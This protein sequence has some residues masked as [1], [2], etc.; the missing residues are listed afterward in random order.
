VDPEVRGPEPQTVLDDNWNAPVEPRL[1]K[2]T[3]VVPKPVEPA[4]TA[5]K[6]V[7]PAGTKP[8][9]GNTGNLAGEANTLFTQSAYEAALARER[10]RMGRT[11]IGVDPTAIADMVIVGGYHLERLAREGVKSFEQWAKAMRAEYG[12]LDKPQLKAVWKELAQQ[13]AIRGLVTHKFVERVDAS[14]EID[15]AT[16]ARLTEREYQPIKDATRREQVQAAAEG[17]TV[18]QVSA[19]ARDKNQ[20][21]PD[22]KRM[23][24]AA[25]A[26]TRLKQ[27]IQAARE[28]GDTT[29][30]ARLAKEQAAVL[31]TATT[32]YEQAGRTLRTARYAFSDVLGEMTRETLGD[33]ATKRLQSKMKQLTP[34]Q[35][36]VIDQMAADA[37]AAPAGFQ[38][39]EKLADLVRHV[40]R[41]TGVPF[42][43]LLLD[44]YYTHIFSGIG[45]HLRNVVDTNLNVLNETAILAANQLITGNPAAAGEILLALARGYGRGLRDAGG[46]MRT[47]VAS[48]THISQLETQSALDSIRFKGGRLNP[49]NAYKYV[50]RGLAAEDVTAFR[51]AEEAKAFDVAYRQARQSGLSRQAA[52]LEARK[53]LGLTADQRAAQLARAQTEGIKGNRLSRRVAEIR[54]QGRSESITDPAVEFGRRATYNADMQGSLAALGDA[55]GSMMN[56]A[57]VLRLIQPVVRIPINVFN[58]GLDY[59]PWGTVRATLGRRGNFLTGEWRDR[60]NGKMTAGERLT[61][62]EKSVGGTLAMAGIA[63]MAAQFMDDENPLFWVHGRGPLDPRQRVQWMNAGGKPYS[64]KINDQYVSYAYTPL[65][66]PMAALGGVL[67]QLRYNNK[68]LSMQD[69]GTQLAA[70]F[71]AMSSA[72]MEQ[73]F[74]SG[75]KDFIDGISDPRSSTRRNMLTGV[76]RKFGNIAIPNAVR[77]VER[78]IDPQATDARNIPQ[79][80]TN[81]FPGLRQAANPVLTDVLGQPVVRPRLKM[82]EAFTTVTTDDPV[83]QLLHQR[84]LWVPDV[85]RNRA[86]GQTPFT[87]DQYY[88]YRETAGRI[89]N[90]YLEQRRGDLARLPQADA[91]ALVQQLAEQ[92]RK[93]ARNQLGLNAPRRPRLSRAL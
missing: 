59:T 24:L 20:V 13:P 26:G 43:N 67:D 33:W 51:A 54:E 80:F 15:V 57:P 77:D 63:A 46:V 42:S 86:E 69:A 11:N 48:G 61:A 8:L 6:N 64:W 16:K 27:E 44:I 18:E 58:R 7:A 31:D 52:R 19:L 92:A 82:V 23:W 65:V 66:L 39:A 56:K 30:V 53:Q 91:Q 71:T 73:A 4:P 35:R 22:D 74:L 93:E 68:K 47:G 81:P 5:D 3:V 83:K 2:P 21:M 72:M 45:T 25:E 76:A 70:A 32:M 1:A 84:Q 49:L 14:A 17:L 10:A 40:D 28:M 34:E 79:S 37:E 9:T 12:T 78:M 38:R 87:E 75:L 50:R 55:V 88:Q 62:L 89:L 60:Y 29:E 36:A 41:Q 90:T 85:S